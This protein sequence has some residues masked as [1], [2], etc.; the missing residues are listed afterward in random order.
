[1]P[2]TKPKYRRLLETLLILSVVILR[3][4]FTNSIC[5]IIAI[6]QIR[7]VMETTGLEQNSHQINMLMTN[8]DGAA[9]HKLSWKRS[10]FLTVNHFFDLP[11]EGNVSPWKSQPQFVSQSPLGSSWGASHFEPDTA[12]SPDVVSSDWTAVPAKQYGEPT[13]LLKYTKWNKLDLVNSCV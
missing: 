5:W 13:W 8:C 12:Q 10:V 6:R 9:W 1:M 3:E 2:H 7:S 11:G 4:F